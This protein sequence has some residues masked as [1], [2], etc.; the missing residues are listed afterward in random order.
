MAKANILIVEDESIIASVIAGALRKF[1]YEVIDIL[2]SGEAAVAVAL[3]KKPDLILMDIRLQ[4]EMDGI[5]A[6][7]RIQKQLDIPIIYL[8]AYADEPTLER[9]KK[10]KPYGYIPKPFQEIELK[11]TIEMALYKHHFEMQL[12]ESEAKFRSLFENSQDVIYIS[13]KSGK[14]SGDESGRTGSFRL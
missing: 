1:E 2:N 4:G 6:V 3:E 13:D 9:A 5:A 12:K 11:T 8:T 7:E 14:L 10:T